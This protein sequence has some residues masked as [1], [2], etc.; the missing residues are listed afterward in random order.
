[1][2]NGSLAENS[3]RDYRFNAKD[4]E[5]TR[6]AIGPEQQNDHKKKTF[7]SITVIA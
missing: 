3:E 2:I 4:R 1:M 6:K 7:V 5:L